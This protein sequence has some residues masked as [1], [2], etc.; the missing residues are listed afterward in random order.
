MVPCAGRGLP[1][2]TRGIYPSTAI[3]AG[4][5]RKSTFLVS[6]SQRVDRSFPQGSS[7]PVL[8]EITVAR[9][10]DTR[11]LFL[12]GPRLSFVFGTF[13]TLGTLGTLGTFGTLGASLERFWSI[14]H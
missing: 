14:F 3:S 9:V 5:A 8:A 6:D 2:G 7:V 10:F 4:K 11:V 1:A 12:V 13:G